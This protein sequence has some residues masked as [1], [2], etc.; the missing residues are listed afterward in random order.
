MRLGASADFVEAIRAAERHFAARGI[1]AQVI[2]KDYYVTE[3]LR[4]VSEFGPPKIIFKGGCRH[5][6]S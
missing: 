2:K 3:A 1:D 4:L 6:R 5:E